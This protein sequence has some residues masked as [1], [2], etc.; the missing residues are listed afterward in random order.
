MTPDFYSF[1]AAYID[2]FLSPVTAS[3]RNRKRR[4]NT[5]PAAALSFQSVSLALQARSPT[6]ASA[7]VTWTTSF[8]A[9]PGNYWLHTLRSLF[10]IHLKGFITLKE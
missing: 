2:T 10:Q 7:R 5:T 9:V 4:R 6:L 3:T 1:L 8:C